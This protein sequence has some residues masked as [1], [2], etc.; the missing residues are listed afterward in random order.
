MINQPLEINKYLFY[1]TLIQ[2]YV[3]SSRF[4]ERKWLAERI[5][6]ELSY[7]NCRFL[8]LT[9][10]PGAG[11]TVLMAQLAR[12]HP[13]WP[14]YFIRRDSQTPLSSGDAR[15][16]L[17]AIGHQ[18]AAQFPILFHPEKLEIAV[19]Q[20]IGEL[21]AGGKVVGI[22][23]DELRV[24]PFYN[25]SLK[26]EQDV[27]IVAGDLEG[28][29]VTKMVAEKRFLEIENLQYLALL[30][31][32]RVLLKEEPDAR[33][34][35]LIDALDELLYY[36][37]RDNI[38][39]WLAACPELP[40]NVRLVITSR[41]EDLLNIL[42]QR[43]QLW[44]KEDIIDAQSEQVHADLRLYAENFAYHEPVKQILAEYEKD[45]SEFVTQAV[46]KADGNFQ[47]LAGLMLGIE[48]A[49]E[50]N[51]KDQL[52]QLVT[53][54][55][56]PVGLENLYSFFLNLIKNDVAGEKIEVSGNTPFEVNLVRVWEGLYQP[57]LGV[58]SVAKEPLN[59]NQ[60]KVFS[61]F[62]GGMRYFISAIERLG[63]FLDNLD[64]RYRLYHSTFAEF[65]HIAKDTG[66]ISQLLS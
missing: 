37:G 49:I 34:V 32:A 35:I 53:L 25:T 33:I 21:A 16:F 8:L 31:P 64:S 63:Q 5:E 52:K 24:S 66:C 1:E 42:R 48:K 7:S 19:K 62:Q 58:L 13:N 65:P 60:I 38:L 59:A 2:S 41:P 57:I 9:A 20:R 10:E 27:N 39:K 11:K 28:I 15:S 61:G 50:Q 56:V 4:I 43:Q 44:L 46:W 23:V 40:S 51:N 17:F 55:N 14:R 29:S 45:S 54:K 47:Y 12:Q 26:V 22:T 6:T 18:L 30:D 3:D 36:Q